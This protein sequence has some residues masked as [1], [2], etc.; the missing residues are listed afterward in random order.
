MPAVLLMEFD[1]ETRRFQ[2]LREVEL[3]S[4]P[5]FGDKVVINIDGIGFIF[6]VY[7]SHYGENSMVDVNVIRISTITDYYG[8][9]Y[10]DIK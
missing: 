1:I 8:T 3:A 7:D 9:R 2:A 6:K 4:V 10:P 5:T